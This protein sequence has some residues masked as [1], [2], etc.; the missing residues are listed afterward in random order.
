M[1]RV[2]THLIIICCII[3]QASAQEMVLPL[4]YNPVKSGTQK[5][6]L[7]S[8]IQFPPLTL[9]FW[10]DFSHPGPF[11][12]PA[13]WMDQYV[14]INSSFGSR[15]IS[16]GVATFDALDENGLLYAHIEANNIPDT[17]DRLTSRPIDLTQFGPE[18]GVALSF[19]YQPEGNSNGPPPED[20]LLILEFSRPAEESGSGL[21]W[22]KIWSSQGQK[23][24]DFIGQDGNHFKRVFVSI[25]DEVYFRED[26]QFR[27]SNLV[28]FPAIDNQSL[29]NYSGTRSIWNIDYV[30]LGQG[31]NAAQS[32]YY[33]LTFGAP[34]QSM[35]REYT[36]MPWSHYII[37]PQ[38]HLRERFDVRISNL[39]QTAYNY[40]Y[41]YVIADEEDRIL[42][43]YS[44][45]SWVIQPFSQ[46]GYQDYQPHANPIVLPNPL[47]NA[48]AEERTFRIIHSIRE[49]ATGDAFRRNDTIVYEQKFASHFAYD[50]GSAENI[51]IVK[52]RDPGVA[53]RFRANHT[54][55][56]KS[57]QVV[58]MEALN[59]NEEAGFYIRVWNHSE[60]G[61]GAH[62]VEYGPFVLNEVRQPDAL[63]TNIPLD[64]GGVEVN[65]DFYVGIVQRGNIT[66]Q[67]AIGMGRDLNYN[68][69]GG[70]LLVD[71]GEGWLPSSQLGTTMIRAVMTQQ[72]TPTHTEDYRQTGA[73]VAY[74]N[75]V[76]GSTIQLKGPRH[77]ENA[78]NPPIMQIFDTQGK[79]LLSE[80]FSHEVDVSNLPNGLYLLRVSSSE[81]RF[82]ET[83]RL[84]IAR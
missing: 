21:R 15:P 20:N 42:R 33:D 71:F 55:I 12:D 51:H 22:E 63:F 19:Y 62:D 6:L 83:L 26:F 17:A 44:G 36:A 30:L 74:P 69:E 28:S 4:H 64:N 76:S 1:R 68:S 47:P 75:P 27:W 18:D 10:D 14:F 50:D 31:R 65:G 70:M 11:P 23:L 73:L 61:Q 40:T 8:G 43:T 46:Y 37:N 9:P 84:V 81:G 78:I 7:K 38:A 49:G 77:E 60:P 66:L 48:P 67:N 35:L 39:D 45:G 41:R 54:D 29:R 34:A 52:G 24:E 53:M 13:L 16:N 80:P 25:D 82:T 3:A 57:V 2:L 79:L 72:D 59:A 58:L 56:L 5:P 32:G